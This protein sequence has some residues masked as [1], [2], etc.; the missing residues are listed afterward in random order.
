[1]STY[2][3]ERKQAKPGRRKREPV[4]DVSHVDRGIETYIE[5]CRQRIPSFVEDNFSLEQTWKLQRP[6]LWFD[7]ACA[8]INSAWALPHLAIHKAAESA[9]RVGYPGFARWVKHLPAGITTGYQ[10]E[11]ER[12]ICRDLLEW[13]V[14][15]K[16]AALPQGLQNDPALARALSGLLHQFSSARALVSDLFATVLTLGFSWLMMGSTSLSLNGIAH[17]LAR[18]NAHDRAASRFFL[19]RKAGSAFYNVFPPAAHESTFWTILFF[20][21]AG[22]TV[23]AMAC[24]IFSDPIRK[25][26]GFHRHRLE[27]LLNEMERELIVLSHKRLRQEPRGRD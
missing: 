7:L 8:P 10:R 9:E 27:V 18:R 25:A 5:R 23:G 15:Q 13:D 4:Q 1:L 14:E 24:T 22:L 11:I 26:L 21:G 2:V 16:A 3:E 17:G 12:R 6:T 19:G 20:L